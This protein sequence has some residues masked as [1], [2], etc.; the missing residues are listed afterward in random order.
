MNL[1]AKIAFAYKRRQLAR[2]NA[3]VARAEAAERTRM[4][5]RDARLSD[6][7]LAQRMKAAPDMGGAALVELSEFVAARYAGMSDVEFLAEL[8]RI[9][10]Q[11]TAVLTERSTGVGG[12][13]GGVPDDLFSERN[14]AH[15]EIVDRELADQATLSFDKVSFDKEFA[16]TWA[17]MNSQVWAGLS[18]RLEKLVPEEKGFGPFRAREPFGLAKREPG[19]GH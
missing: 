13:T 12:P 18:A 14:A 11:N 17:V 15:G 1:I 6:D 7:E 3:A 9:S 8:N 2:A 19:D 4:V 16:R 10:A 5:L